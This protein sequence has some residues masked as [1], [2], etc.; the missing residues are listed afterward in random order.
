MRFSPRCAA[1]TCPPARSSS[2]TRSVVRHRREI[3]HCSAWR[4]SST[5]S[6]ASARSATHHDELG[7]DAFKLRRTPRAAMR[8]SSGAAAGLTRALVGAGRISDHDRTW[9]DIVGDDRSG[10]DQG[11]LA[12][13][14]PSEDDR[15]GAE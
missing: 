6:T 2:A 4:L 10:T 11:P 7:D 5:R 14:D 15:T 1:A 3:P 8:A 12:D 9:L 13:R